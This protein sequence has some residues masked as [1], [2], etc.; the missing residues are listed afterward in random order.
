MAQSI[1]NDQDYNNWIFELPEFENISE[2][3]YQLYNIFESSYQLQDINYNYFDLIH[4]LIRHTT[5]IC[6]I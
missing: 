5:Y 6:S 3:S 1:N 2:G 4:I